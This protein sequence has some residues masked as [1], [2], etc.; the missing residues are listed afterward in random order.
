M[1]FTELKGRIY[2]TVRYSFQIF[3]VRAHHFVLLVILLLVGSLLLLALITIVL[4]IRHV[5][6]VLLE[7]LQARVDLEQDAARLLVLQVLSRFRLAE[8]TNKLNLGVVLAQTVLKADAVW[9][10]PLAL[11]LALHI[12]A[13]IVLAAANAV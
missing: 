4:R 1:G 10:V 2:F 7:V 8:G 9:M 12:H 3:S 13:V 11:V 6:A 5:H